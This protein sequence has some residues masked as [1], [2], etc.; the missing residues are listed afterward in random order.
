MMFS[1]VTPL[2]G[3]WGHKMLEE[4]K[5]PAA[6][7]EGITDIN[8]IKIKSFVLD[9]DQR[10]FNRIQF[11]KALGRS[12][13]AKG[14][15][16]YDMEFTVPVFLGA[17][18]L[19]PFI[20]KGLLENSRPIFFKDKNGKESIGYKAELLPEVCNVY[21]DAHEA[22]AFDKLMSSYGHII[23]RCKMLIRGFATVGIIALV[24]EATG[25]QYVRDRLALEKILKVYINDEL[26]KW[27]KRFPDEWYENLFRLWGWEWK[28]RGV[29]P[30][31]IVGKITREIIYER[32]PKGVIDELEARNPP[33]DRGIRKTKHHQWLTP[34]IGHPKLQEII[35]G[36]NTLMRVSPNWRKFKELLSRAFPKHG[37]QQSIELD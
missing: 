22:H 28:G 9:N 6:T 12:G 30:P 14:G 4:K 3:Q 8:G 23:Q 13:K 32:L 17:N 33:D 16:K 19:K 11:I 31:Q 29:N 2:S 7:H 18:V 5:L 34:E 20:N 21:L 35:T 37:D 27:Q 36:T 25:Y 1:L 15:R 26:M 10:V 24:D